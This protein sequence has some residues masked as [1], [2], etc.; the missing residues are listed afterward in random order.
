MNRLKYL[1]PAPHAALALLTLFAASRAKAEPAAEQHKTPARE[2]YARPLRAFGKQWM[3]RLTEDL[4]Y[5]F[6]FG[7]GKDF[8]TMP[9][10]LLLLQRAPVVDGKEQPGSLQKVWRDV[11]G[12]PMKGDEEGFKVYADACVDEASKR[13][14]Q[15]R[16]AR[17]IPALGPY[18]VVDIIGWDDVAT[19]PTVNTKVHVAT[20]EEIKAWIDAHLLVPRSRLL[21][22][23]RN[24]ESARIEKQGDDLIITLPQT[25]KSEPRFAVSLKTREWRK[26][27]EL[28][29]AKPPEAPEPKPDAPP[30]R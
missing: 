30:A 6:K 11:E 8:V 22:D 21:G 13:I 20:D 28:D 17:G 18:V 14:Y 4:T 12:L 10:R 7:M 1:R 26:L 16:A 3:L 9:S 27:P 2:V 5:I 19:E 25:D 15:V 23:N 24:T 29:N